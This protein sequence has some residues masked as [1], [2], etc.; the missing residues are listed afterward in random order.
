MPAADTGA[1]YITTSMWGEDRDN[2]PIQNNQRQSSRGISYYV[3]L[4][5]YL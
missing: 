5:R 4:S 2:R 1:S 3:V